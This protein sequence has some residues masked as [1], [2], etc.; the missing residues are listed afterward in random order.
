MCDYVTKMDYSSGH[1]LGKYSIT[2][3]TDYIEY[4]WAIKAEQRP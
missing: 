2:D 3:A 4:G 1:A